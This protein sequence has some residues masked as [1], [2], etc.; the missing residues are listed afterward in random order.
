MKT[1]TTKITCDV[2]WWQEGGRCYLEPVE[3]LP[4]GR[5]TKFAT[6]R[7]NEFWSKREALATMFSSWAQPAPHSPPTQFT[8]DT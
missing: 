3:R 5:S 7:C 2:C 4:D 1:E 6:T 8:N